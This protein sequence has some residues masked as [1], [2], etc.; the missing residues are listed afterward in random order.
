MKKDK[1]IKE[2]A[3]KAKRFYLLRIKDISGV[4]GIGKVAEGLEFENGMC[5]LSF[6]SSFQHVNTYANIRAV[7][8][9][10]GHQGSTKIVWV[11]KDE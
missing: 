3:Y 7:D 11:D 4:S 1:T 8:E 6:S 2:P 10:H 5:A 9:V